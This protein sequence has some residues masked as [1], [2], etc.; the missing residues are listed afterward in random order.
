MNKI[1]LL[2][3]LTRNPEL[4]NF[5]ETTVTNFTIAVNRNYKNKDGQYEADFINC[6]AFKA[7]GE[8]INKYFL[9]GQMIAVFG[10]LQTRNY[11]DK[12]GNKRFVTE[13]V[14]ESA[15]FAG[16]SKKESTDN[17]TSNTSIENEIPGNIKSNYSDNGIHLSDEDLPF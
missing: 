2:G 6:I 10:R 9:K 14:V 15:E 13:V 8:F 5:N 11:D 7:I 4:K 12:D 1:C 3:R 16:E 17:S